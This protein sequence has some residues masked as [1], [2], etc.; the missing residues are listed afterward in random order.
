[1]NDVCALSNGHD[2]LSHA[3][4][5]I[6]LAF[7]QATM[8]C[9]MYCAMPTV[10]VEQQFAGLQASV[11]DLQQQAQQDAQSLTSDLER[12]KLQL[13]AANQEHDVLEA[14]L[15]E[16]QEDRAA[17][18]GKLAQSAGRVQVLEGEG[19][20]LQLKFDSAKQKLTAAQK[21]IADAEVAQQASQQLCAQLRCELTDA[22]TQSQTARADLA[23]ASQ[24]YQKLQT[25]FSDAQRQSTAA[26][27]QLSAAQQQCD[28]LQSELSEAVR[29]SKA[30]GTDLADA[31]TQCQTLTAEL[32]AAQ[33]QAAAVG[34]ELADAQR[35][36][37]TL[38][39]DLADAEGKSKATSKELS[40]AHKHCQQLVFEL[41]DARRQSKSVSA[42]LSDAQQ[43]SE[44]FK[45]ELAAAGKALV[46]A[47]E[48]ERHTNA[49]WSAAERRLE[50]EK[51]ALQ[52]TT[53]L[54]DSPLP[55]KS[56]KFCLHNVQVAFVHYC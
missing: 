36:H 12:T 19:Q 56:P 26:T 22:R 51:D 6:W 43:Q 48:E 39:S 54:P 18:E 25:D 4:R 44:V 35:Q 49:S 28:K 9:I 24:R 27:G 2:P 33:R 40:D 23:E 1:M 20:Q 55:Q 32:A 3:V 11:K 17:L 16:S 5:H 47:Q 14:S 31:H 45:A 41:S 53:L 46:T 8:S 13:S 42:Q 30:R 29:Q 37:Q 21:Q 15:L 7:H 52:V 34:A 38:K 50:A 10:G